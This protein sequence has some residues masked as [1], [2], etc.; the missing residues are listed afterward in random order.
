[1]SLSV[2]QHTRLAPTRE[3]RG[4]SR[5]QPLPKKETPNMW[6]ECLLGRRRGTGLPNAYDEA[7][8]FIRSSP[9][10]DHTLIPIKRINH[11]LGMDLTAENDNRHVLP[12]IGKDSSLFRGAI[13]TPL[14]GMAFHDALL[15]RPSIGIT[16]WHS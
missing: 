7:Y 11:F 1:M 13:L 12:A 9:S 15:S 4:L 10:R 2:C 8:G 3:S 6:E 16:L 14:T 5:C